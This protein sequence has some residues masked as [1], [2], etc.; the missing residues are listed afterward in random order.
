MDHKQSTSL[1]QALRPTVYCPS[2]SVDQCMT[3]RKLTGHDAP[4]SETDDA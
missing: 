4:R 3:E 1:A 2:G